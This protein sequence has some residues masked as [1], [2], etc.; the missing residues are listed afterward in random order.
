MNSLELRDRI[1]LRWILE[2]QI[3]FFITC[4]LRTSSHITK[5]SENYKLM[6]QA[7]ESVIGKIW[8]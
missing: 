6:G 7:Q 1:I 2:M 8:Y 4:A 5:M 3:V